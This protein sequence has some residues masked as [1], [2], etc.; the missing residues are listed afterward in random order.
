MQMLCL[1]VLA[2]P[3]VVPVRAAAHPL[4][5][6]SATAYPEARQNSK[7]DGLPAVPTPQPKELLFTGAV[8][9][10]LLALAQRFRGS[11]VR[12]G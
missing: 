5:R 1:A 12:L 7:L 10:L 4:P 11:K 8:G 6:I 9:C 3:G 2:I